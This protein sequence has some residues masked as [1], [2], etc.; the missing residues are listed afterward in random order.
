VP[1]DRA[2]AARFEVARR[3]CEAA[4]RA[5]VVAE[6]RQ[7]ARRVLEHGRAARADG[8]V[9]HLAL[10]AAVAHVDAEID[11]V[12]ARLARHP[13]DDRVVGV[14]HEDRLRKRPQH[15]QPA[16][17]QAVDLAIAV[18]LVAEEVG[19]HDHPGPPEGVDG[20]RHDRLVDLEQGETGFGPARESG[21]DARQQVGA[22]AVVH[23]VAAGV[24]ERPG[25]HVGGRGLA[26]RAGH[27]GEALGEAP[28]V[29]REVAREQKVHDLA[30]HAARL[31]G[32]GQA[33]GA[34]HGT[35]GEA[36]DQLH[37]AV[38]ITRRATKSRTPER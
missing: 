34:R 19:E 15:G 17:R 38:H 11:G 9:A 36:R 32:A 8:D 7:P 2:Q 13:C 20:G 16:G 31:A 1:G 24:G 26:V 28:R 10:G 3:S 4:R 29:R 25:R 23:E 5:A 21:G 30:G 22:L 12:Q 33:H 37:G 18:E 27:D 6:L 14:G 35:G